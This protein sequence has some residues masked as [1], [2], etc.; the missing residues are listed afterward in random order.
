MPIMHKS[1]QWLGALRAIGLLPNLTK[2]V[3]PLRWMA[4]RITPFGSDQ[5]GMLVEV[6]GER[7]PDTLLD[8][9][10]S[11]AEITKNEPHL[12]AYR[13]HLAAKPGQGPY[14]P[15]I[16]TRAL[17]RHADQIRFGARACINELPLTQYV[18]AMDDLDIATSSE[19]QRFDYL[20]LSVLGEHWQELP[21]S[22]RNSHRVVD[23][24]TLEGQAKITRGTSWIT[25]LI[26]K[27]FRFPSS[28]ESIPVQVIKTRSANT[29]CWQRNFNAQRFKSTLSSGPS[30]SGH[31]TGKLIQEQ[32]GLLTFL[33]QLDID[34]DGMHFRVISGSC[35]GVPIPHALLPISNTREFE[36]DATMHFCVELLAPFKL[37]LI[38]RYEGWLK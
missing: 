4:E 15:T 1:L 7:R 24:K 14:V 29:E 23:Q 16:P 9:D 2:F 25:Q 31:S 3:S 11:M 21:E 37:G 38:V 34:A 35:L 26:A 30:G 17:L 8:T 28:A 36:K 6:I 19:N 13:W 20:F 5:G 27:I 12:L 18:Q 10:T 33:L 32:F 22:V